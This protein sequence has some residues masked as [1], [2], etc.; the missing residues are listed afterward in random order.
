MSAFHKRYLNLTLLNDTA[1]PEECDQM[2]RQLY[3]LKLLCERKSLYLNL[4]CSNCLENPNITSK[5]FT[6]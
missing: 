5:H 3:M 6:L 1:S 2:T 4:P